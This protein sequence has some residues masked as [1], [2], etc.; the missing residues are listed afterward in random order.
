MGRK[1][2]EHFLTEVLARVDFSAPMAELVD[3]IPPKVS[4]EALQN[5]P[6]LEPKMVVGEGILLKGEHGQEEYRSTQREWNYFGK[7]RDKRLC[8]T[9]EAMF[10]VHNQYQEFES[11]RDEFLAAVGPMFIAYPD[12]LLS[13]F[14]LRYVNKI[15][16]REGDNPTDWSQYLHE[17]LLSI[18]SV[19][20]SSSKVARAFHTLVLN[21]EELSL[22]FQYGMHNP[23]YP[24]EI[25]KK[26]FVLDFDAYYQGPLDLEDLKAKIDVFHDKI[27]TLFEDS[28]TPDLRRE[29]GEET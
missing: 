4:R 19:A 25:T 2:R 10:V 15:T 7:Q 13:R 8:I 5:F 23:D 18:F 27:E 14:G 24:A 26:E 3:S 28:I 11:F 6:I 20:P 12:L 16:L 1:Y 22:K 9:P 29:M 21:F 17:N